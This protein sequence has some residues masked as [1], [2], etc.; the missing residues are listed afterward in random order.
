M[1]KI[2]WNTAFSVNHSEIDTQHQEWFRLYNELRQDIIRFEN[3]VPDKFV[4]E[5]LTAMEQYSKD[6]FSFEEQYMK[7]M[8]YPG[9]ENH[10]KKHDDFRHKIAAYRRDNEQGKPV[11]NKDLLAFI[12]TWLTDH[13]LNEDAGYRRF[14]EKSDP[15]EV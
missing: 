3:G 12:R 2:E 11:L 7:D 10:I 6:H 15:E 4:P 1:P 13:V 5:S 9:L 14:K 8:V